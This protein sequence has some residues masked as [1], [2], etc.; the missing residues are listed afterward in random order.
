MKTGISRYMVVLLLVSGLAAAV[1][2]GGGGGGGSAGGIT[3]ASV[4]PFYPVNGVDWNDYVKNDSASIYEASDTAATGT[5]TGGYDVLLHGGEMRAFE[6][7]GK[8]SCTGLTVTDS[9]G[10][11]EWFCDESTDP[12]TMISTGLADDKGLSDL[13][14]F[15]SGNWK[16][17]SV[18]VADS[19]GTYG[20]TPSSR[21]WNNPIVSRNSGG[22]LATPG[23]VYIV[24]TATPSAPYVMAGDKVALTVQPGISMQGPGTGSRVVAATNAEKFLWF[25]GTIDATGYNE[26]ISW[27][28]F[29]S[30]LRN[31]EVHSGTLD[32]IQLLSSL[33]GRFENI[34]THDNA[35]WGVW[36][37]NS[38]RNKLEDVR[39]SGN[40]SG[41][42]LTGSNDNEIEE[43]AAINNTF[44]G[45]TISES[46]RNKLVDIRSA[47]NA[48]S[49]IF[50]TFFSHEN[51]LSHV[52]SNNNSL[53][54]ISLEDAN[55]NRFL[56]VTAFANGSH[57]I[58][59]SSSVN[60]VFSNVTSAINKDSG[61]SVGGSSDGNLFMNLNAANHRGNGVGV[62]SSGSN[63]FI[64]V[65]AA[66]NNVGVGLVNSDNNFF[67][68][69]LKVGDHLNDC[70]VSG[71]APGLIQ[72]NCT[73]SGAYGS[74]DYPGQLSTAVLY[75]GVDMSLS[76]IGKV[77]V[78]DSVNSSDTNGT[79]LYDSI[80]DWTSFQNDYR[81]WGRDGLAFAD[82]TN[83]GSVGTGATA[84]I[85]DMSL[86]ATGDTGDAGSP[87]L[88]NTLPFP[89]NITTFTHA[90]S[91]S[92]TSTFLVNTVEIIGDGI[93]NDNTLCES[94]ETCLKTF[95]IGSYQGH[96][97]LLDV[98]MW[99]TGGV[100]N[101]TLME[102]M[103][104]GY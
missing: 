92:P 16:R 54:G 41:L 30:V 79:A 50:V 24:T 29:F 98:G 11:F 31:V 53:L 15:G 8:S 67:G 81:G 34:Y 69:F 83:Q 5:E 57:G 71:T 43:V 2:C 56:D 101:V 76:F 13:I 21:W 17:L 82:T 12:V 32:G 47:N 49:G 42:L 77:A 90:W 78:D 51:T 19:T 100:T 65:A 75:N 52:I 85:W 40:E 72:P 96:G 23:S 80:T 1:S 46:L 73:N 93:G 63:D 94:N 102:Y 38:F 88:V 18:A 87:V 33:S 6:V 74:T 22:T 86:P 14:D 68:G 45:L 91:F 39:T 36:M 99:V 97:P 58:S 64:N 59:L 35:N 37:E 89:G 26:G 28:T 95:N 10:A 103:T 55:D 60:N 25:E 61:I 3:L 66:H 104:N 62:F 70:G 9:A 27:E 20:T 7:T 84:R 4:E 44:N 48:G